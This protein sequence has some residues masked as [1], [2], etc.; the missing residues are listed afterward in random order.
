M[1]PLLHMGKS[2]YASDM[3]SMASVL[4]QYGSLYAFEGLY[5]FKNKFHP[6][7][8]VY[9]KDKPLFNVLLSVIRLIN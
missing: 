4:Y 3:E 9:K 1:A 7:Y 5:R 6:K 8:L 2:Y